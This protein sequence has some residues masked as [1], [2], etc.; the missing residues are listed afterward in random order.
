MP[1]AQRSS[2]AASTLS[3]STSM[4]RVEAPADLEEGYEFDVLLHGHPFTVTVPPGGVRE[5][6]TLEI[7]YP[8]EMYQQQQRHNKN[9]GETDEE[10][11]PELSPQATMSTDSEESAR[12]SPPTGRWRTHVCACCDVL[13][14]ATFWMACCCPPVLLAQL[15][16]RLRLN[17]QGVPDTPLE[18]SLAY[19]K[20]VMSFVVA[21]VL[22]KIPVLGSVIVLLYCVFLLLWTGRRVRSHMRTTHAIPTCWEAMPG[23]VEDTLCMCCCSCCTL[24]QMARH[25]HPDKEYPGYCCTTTGLEPSAPEIIYKTV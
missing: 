14:Q 2:V 1:V 19:N 15:V 9:V 16:T 12:L 22:G 4:V 5:G 7:P 24:M 23:A 25:T 3:Q 6:E 10:H 18:T 8:R 13:T 11:Y 21:L 20:I 17:W